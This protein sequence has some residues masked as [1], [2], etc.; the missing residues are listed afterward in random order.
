MATCFSDATETT[1]RALELLTGYEPWSWINDVFIVDLTW[2]LLRSWVTSK[3]NS[4]PV[5]DH[6]I[7]CVLRVIGMKRCPFNVEN[8]GTH[9]CA[10][11]SAVSFLSVWSPGGPCTTRLM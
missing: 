7:Q 2:P 3:R 9:L 5:S 4:A 8:R 11:W 6:H 1:C 10:V